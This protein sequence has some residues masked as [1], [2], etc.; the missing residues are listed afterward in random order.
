M[1]QPQAEVAA[2][3]TCF[4]APRRR[5]ETQTH[6]NPFIAN[7]DTETIMKDHII[8]IG[9]AIALRRIARRD[10]RILRSLEPRILR[11]IG[12]NPD[13]LRRELHQH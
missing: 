5:L 9:Q 6:D 11:D 8:R 4:H 12:L 7:R 3:E 1:F 10:D 13:N 2:I